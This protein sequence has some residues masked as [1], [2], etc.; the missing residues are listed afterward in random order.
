MHAHGVGPQAIAH[1]WLGL[2]PHGISEHIPILPYPLGT[3][4]PPC[5]TGAI[6]LREGVAHTRTIDAFEIHL[7]GIAQRVFCS[8]KIEALA[9]KI[10]LVYSKL[11]SS[12][13]PH[14][15]SSNKFSIDRVSSSA[16]CFQ[17]HGTD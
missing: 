9:T 7:T 8:T 3:D 4:E 15:D 16:S 10:T 2:Q 14:S 1:M 11:R 12:I 5:K 6:C 17:F 13:C